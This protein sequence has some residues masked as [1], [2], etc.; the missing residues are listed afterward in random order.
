M[1]R[2]VKILLVL[3]VAAWGPV[4]AF[5]NI[6]DW[7]GTTGAVGATTTMAGIEGDIAKWQATDN[8]LVITLGAA[9]IPSLKFVSAILCLVGALAMW[10][11]RDGDTLEFQRAKQAA[12]AGCAVTVLL[13]FAGWIVIAESWVHRADCPD[14]RPARRLTAG[15]CARLPDCK[16]PC[17]Y[18]ASR[19]PARPFS[20]SLD[21]PSELMGTRAVAYGFAW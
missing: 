1:Y 2:S 14:G 21:S 6:L 17:I 9:M 10:R 7:G 20:Q 13:L 3:A 4:G 12:L 15:H 16:I 5:F 18:G 19:V 11:A 8:A